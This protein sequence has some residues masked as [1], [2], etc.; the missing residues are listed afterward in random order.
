[1]RLNYISACRL[2][3]IW[4][5]NH[6]PRWVSRR[7]ITG[8]G[9]GRWSPRAPPG[10]CGA[11]SRSRWFTP[12]GIIRV[13][14]TR[15]APPRRSLHPG[16]RPEGLHSGGRRLRARSRQAPSRQA[17]PDRP[18]PAPPFAPP[19]GRRRSAVTVARRPRRHRSCGTVRPSPSRLIPA[20]IT[21]PA[22]AA[23]TSPLRWPRCGGHRCGSASMWERRCGSAGAGVQ[24][25]LGSGPLAMGQDMQ[26]GPPRPEPSSEP[27]M[28]STSMPASSR[29]AFVWVL[30]S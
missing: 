14:A 19:F 8:S 17:R 16:G 4:G 24:D 28:A 27:A 18:V 6:G 5:I 12:A 13:V 20:P 15:A 30:R 7:E 2:S 29:R 21:V 9:S 26:R 25:A 22:V 10:R 1:M 11:G 23:P 3:L